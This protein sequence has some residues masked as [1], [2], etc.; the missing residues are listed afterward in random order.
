[1]TLEDIKKM[2]R[3]SFGVEYIADADVLKLKRFAVLVAEIEREACAKACDD[4]NAF[5][6]YVGFSRK[7]I[8]AE[9]CAKDIRSRKNK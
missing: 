2:A 9:R 8:A 7:A 4:K 3:E 6:K 5:Y 1:M